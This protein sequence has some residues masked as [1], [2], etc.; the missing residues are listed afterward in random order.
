MKKTKKYLIFF[1]FLYIKIVNI[2]EI[3]NKS[4]EKKHVK[5]IKISMKKKNKKY[6]KKKSLRKTSKFYRRKKRK[7]VSVLLVRYTEAT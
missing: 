2:I 4:I 3:T 6:E 1:F 5:D 7:K